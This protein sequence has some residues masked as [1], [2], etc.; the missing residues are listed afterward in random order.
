MDTGLR[1]FAR[2]FASMLAALAILLIAPPHA[3]ADYWD[4]TAPFCNGKCHGNDVQKGSSKC[5][6]GGCCWTGHKALCGSPTP[7][8]PANQTNTE[9]F[10]IV[11]ICDNGYHSVPNQV[12]HSCNKY[13][14]GVCIGLT[15]DSYVPSNC[16]EGLVA[17][18]AV[19]GDEACVPPAVHDEAVR[20]NQAAASRREPAGGQ[21]GPDT[22]KQGFVWREVVPTDH[23]CVTPDVRAQNASYNTASRDRLAS[24][25]KP[26]GPDTCVQGFVWREAIRN[27][28]VCVTPGMR[29]QARQDN[30]QASA[31]RSPNGGAFGAD[32]CKQGFVWREVVPSDHVCVPPGIRD[33]TAA[34][35]RAAH[36]R[37]VPN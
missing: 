20:D 32:T 8:C 3:K 37:R 23:V 15:L 1:I 21:F 16:K 4:G 9:C 24:G 35:N 29:D 26:Y 14:C 6:D 10:G 34:D 33:Q 22:C 27:D 5:G 2:P 19:M 17:R 11:E 30:A 31:R 36:D 12:W 28:H 25:N 13:A 18:G 7:S